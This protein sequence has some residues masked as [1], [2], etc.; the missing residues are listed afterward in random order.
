MKKAAWIVV[1]VGVALSVF[2]ALFSYRPTPEKIEYGVTFSKLFAD[3]LD[4]DWIDV[5][6]AALSDLGIR[7]FR[8]VAHWPMIEPERDV[9]DFSAMD[10]QIREARTYDAEV[11]LAIGRRL[12]RWPEC[13]TPRWV[14][15]M[16]WE[17]QKMEI[18]QY[19]TAVVERYKDESIITHWQVENEPYLSLFAQE[20]CGSLDEEFLHEEVA[21]VKSLDPSRPVLVTDSGNLGLWWKPYRLGDAFGTSLYIYF[22]NPELGQFKTKLP[23]ALYRVKTNLM[24]VFGDKPTY[25]IELSAEPWLVEPV[26]NVDIETQLERMDAKKFKEIILYAEKTHFDEQY[27]WGV[28]WWY[29]MRENGHPEFWD[30]AKELF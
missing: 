23:A 1:C 19:L 5:Y 18:R 27:L 12:P 3:E 30:Y 11:I 20:I 17:E 24:R 15:N 28:E 10:Y 26:T 16:E 13:H 8:L 29:Y 7:K 14:G 22:W 6:Q 2:A 25:L 9:Y 21:L 4:A